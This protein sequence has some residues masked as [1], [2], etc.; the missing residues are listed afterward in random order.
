M[1]ISRISGLQFTRTD[2]EMEY[3]MPASRHHISEVCTSV[4]FR[5][6][7]ERAKNFVGVKPLKVA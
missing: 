6:P 4:Y 2:S 7:G 3:G 5:P 1:T